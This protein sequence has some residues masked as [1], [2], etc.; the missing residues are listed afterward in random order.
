MPHGMCEAAPSFVAGMIAV[1]AVSAWFAL[2]SLA[3]YTR[4]APPRAQPKARRS[5][6]ATSAIVALF[7]PCAVL[8]H[9]AGWIPGSSVTVALVLVGLPVGIAT[10]LS[11]VADIAATHDAI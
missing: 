8:T 2:I 11:R 9:T 4:I 6:F 5:L 7:T 3:V 1:I 10:G